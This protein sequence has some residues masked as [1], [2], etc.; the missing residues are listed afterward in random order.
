LTTN[1]DGTPTGSGF[2]KPSCYHIDQFES[3]RP[4]FK[5]EIE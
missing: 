4:V 2:S 1:P 5:K 3:L